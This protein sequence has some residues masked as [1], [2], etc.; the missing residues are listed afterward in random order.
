MKLDSSLTIVFGALTLVATIAAIR[1]K[2][3]VGSLVMKIIRRGGRRGVRRV[4][5]EPDIELTSTFPSEDTTHATGIE[6]ASLP[7]V[8]R[9]TYLEWPVQSPYDETRQQ[10]IAWASV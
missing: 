9:P 10:Q 3:S 4:S 2:K 7:S 1:Y 5:R 6:R 8:Y